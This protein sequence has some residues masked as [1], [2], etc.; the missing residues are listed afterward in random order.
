VVAGFG[1]SGS[2]QSWRIRNGSESA[3]SLN[4]QLGLNH[5]GYTPKPYPYK[6]CPIAVCKY[7]HRNVEA[8]Q[9]GGSLPADEEDEFLGVPNWDEAVAIQ[10]NPAVY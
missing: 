6:N 2:V 9:K 10:D 4:Q 8:P 7:L 5:C 3:H 1:L